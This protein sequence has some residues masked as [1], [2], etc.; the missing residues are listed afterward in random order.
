MN[1]VNLTPHTINIYEFDGSFQ[2]MAIPPSGQIAR[3][4]ATYNKIGQI[5]GKLTIPEVD[6]TYGKPEGL[7]KPEENTLFIVSGMFLAAC[8][9]NDLRKPGDLVRNEAGQPIGCKGLCV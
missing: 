1:I 7:P 8:P 4:E 6:V 9:R 2:I 3:I 5:A